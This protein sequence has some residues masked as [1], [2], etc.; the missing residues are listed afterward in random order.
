MLTYGEAL[1]GTQKPLVAAGTLGSSGQLGR[2]ATEEDPALPVGDEHKGHPALMD[3]HGSGTC[4]GS[5]L[6]KGR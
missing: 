4:Q 6:L 3:R 5:N 1:A 2:S